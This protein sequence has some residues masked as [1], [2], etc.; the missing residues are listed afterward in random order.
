[1][2]RAIAIGVTALL[3][4]WVPAI[5]AQGPPSMLQYRILAMEEGVWDADITMTLPGQQATRSKGVEI[6][7]L[8]G[9][10]WLISDF[11]GE[12]YGRPFEGHGVN[13][14]DA[15][16]GKYVATWVDSLSARIDQMEGTYDE[17]T[18]T[19]AL[20]ADRKDAASGRPIKIRLATQLKDDDT[21]IFI[22]SVQMDG[23]K[24]FVKFME[25][26]YTKR[27]R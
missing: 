10:K 1:M 17:K 21:R 23:E 18:K 15:D 8:L 12:L 13:G 11:K 19:L 2:G 20:Y 5:K 3:M 4:I 6:N 14:Y 16:K 7:R 22:E 9:G 25:V 27:K 26:K 24:D